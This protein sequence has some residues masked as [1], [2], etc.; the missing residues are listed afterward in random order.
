MPEVAG[1]IFREYLT[2]MLKKIDKVKS[3]LKWPEMRELL[4]I[5]V[6]LHIFPVTDLRHNVISPI[7][8]L[9]GQVS[10]LFHS[11]AA[12]DYKLIFMKFVSR[13]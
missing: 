4:L 3:T 10:F 5:R 8:L 11:N 6:A 12:L 13:Y 7:E 9:I 1:V 2:N